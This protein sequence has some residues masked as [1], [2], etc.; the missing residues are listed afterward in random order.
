[1]KMQYSGFVDVRDSLALLA[2]ILEKASNVDFLA[3]RQK[4]ADWIRSDI[5]RLNESMEEI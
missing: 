3:Y 4:F 5:E 1:M 2:G